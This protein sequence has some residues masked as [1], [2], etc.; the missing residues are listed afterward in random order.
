MSGI[1]WMIVLIVWHAAVIAACV[2]QTGAVG[3]TLSGR[4]LLTDLAVLCPLHA[5]RR[6]RQLGW[7]GCSCW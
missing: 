3:H 1:D 7:L 5:A 2:D 6:V 4:S